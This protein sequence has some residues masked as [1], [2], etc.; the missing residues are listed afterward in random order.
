M[1]AIRIRRARQ[2]DAAFIAGLRGM[3]ETRLYQPVTQL[4]PGEVRRRLRDR[5][6]GSL[7]EERGHELMWIIEEDERAAGWVM[8]SIRD[9]SHRNARIGYTLHPGAWGRGAALTGVAQVL[10]L[11]FGPGRM[12]RIDCDVMV[13][14]E[15]SQKLVERLGFTQ[16][17][18]LRSLADMPGGRR[19]F[20]LYSILDDEWPGSEK[21]LERP[22]PS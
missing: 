19:D 17:G 16:E 6:R 13:E 10:D 7:S 9:W 1:S 4:P 5:E 11:A 21:V 3:A 22:G 14:N 18:R 20:F 12:R 8:L 15:R 2:G